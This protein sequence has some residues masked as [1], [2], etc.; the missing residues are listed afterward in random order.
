[1]GRRAW[2]FTGPVSLA[3]GGPWQVRAWPRGRRCASFHI[4]VWLA[5]N[6]SRTLAF[7]RSRTHP[8]LFLFFHPVPPAPRLP[9]R[10][11]SRRATTGPAHLSP[12]HP[13]PSAQEAH[14][15]KLPLAFPR[16]R[17]RLQRSLHL[18]AVD[19]VPSLI[20]DTS[21]STRA[22]RST[23]RFASV[24]GARAMAH[25][26]HPKQGTPSRRCAPAWSPAP[27]TAGTAANTCQ[28]A[29]RY[30]ENPKSRQPSVLAPS[31]G[32]E[33]AMQSYNMCLTSC[34]TV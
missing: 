8:S 20:P 27:V 26:A 23:G 30:E 3:G 18:F 2:P 9:A 16:R 6:R 10:H 22:H 32:M 25:L 19:S 12:P 7:T 4:V 24:R 28:A 11:L 34:T 15:S 17:R 1:M 29:M 5:C 13:L 14:P 31:H 21:V 33:P